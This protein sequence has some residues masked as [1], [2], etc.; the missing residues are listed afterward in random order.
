[1]WG[2]KPP[3]FSCTVMALACSTSIRDEDL[4]K[5][6]LGELSALETNNDRYQSEGAAGTLWKTSATDYPVVTL[7]DDDFRWLYSQKVVGRRSDARRLYDE[8]LAS[9]LL[10]RC[11]Y[12]NHNRPRT[13]DHFLPKSDYASLAI[14]PWNLVPCCGDCNHQMLNAFATAGAEYGFHPYFETISEDWLVVDIIDDAGVAAVFSA[15]CPTHWPE[16]LAL[17]VRHS[18]QA[19][20]LADLYASA[21]GG[22]I[23]ELRHQVE[24]LHDEVGPDA[25]R[26]HLQEA[27]DSVGKV[28]PNNWRAVLYRGLADSAWFCSGGF[29]AN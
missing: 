19:L 4:Q 3:G 20:R 7:S 18:F 5:R 21:S 13:L 15:S 23:A 27:S 12:C 11:P 28:G 10:D 24:R 9:A 25:V 1:M 8:L 29:R 26:S 17:R 14:D 16:E 2:A 6:L 22:A